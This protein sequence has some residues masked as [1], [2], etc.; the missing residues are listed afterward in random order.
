MPSIPWFE[1][2][3]FL[4]ATICGMSLSTLRHDGEF[5]NKRTSSLNPEF[6]VWY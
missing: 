3:Q 1:S 5:H 6:E 2:S 4:K